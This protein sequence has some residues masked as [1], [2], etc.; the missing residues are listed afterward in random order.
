[1]SDA[2]VGE[3]TLPT[4]APGSVLGVPA[5]VLPPAVLVQPPC[6]PTGLDRLEIWLCKSLIRHYHD[7]PTQVGV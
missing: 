6:H 7:K 1:M 3:D 2:G 5:S 4:R